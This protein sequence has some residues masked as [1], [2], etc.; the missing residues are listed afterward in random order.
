[1]GTPSPARGVL[2]THRTTERSSNMSSPRRLEGQEE[3]VVPRSPPSP[4][5][6]SQR[7]ERNS[8]IDAVKQI[9]GAQ[10]KTPTKGEVSVSETPEYDWDTRYDGIPGFPSH[11]RNRISE[12]STPQR[13]QSTRSGPGTPP[14]PQR[15]F[16]QLKV[17]DETPAG[18]PLPA[19]QQIRQANLRKIFEEEGADTPC[20]IC[21]DPRHYHRNCTKE[22]YLES[23]DL[24]QDHREEE[25]TRGSVHT[26]IFHT[27]EFALVYGVISQD[28]L[29]RTA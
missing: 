15:Y 8:A 19:L 9:T 20:D 6:K 28:I 29:H 10:K 17:Y 3:R 16:K 14:K 11:L 24:R 7:E 5:K 18:R 22:A 4:D 23:Q 13:G 2:E 21:R 27:Q 25:V 26:V 12:P 1:M